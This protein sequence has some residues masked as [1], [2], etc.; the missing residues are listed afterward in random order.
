MSEHPFLRGMSM[1]VI[2]GAAIG[3]AVVPKKK[4]LK[5]SAAK[6]IKAMGEMMEHVTDAMKM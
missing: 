5:N 4:A 6:T 3:M 1:G 2:A